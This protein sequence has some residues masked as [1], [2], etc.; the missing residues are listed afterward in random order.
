MV[1]RIH[2]RSL[3]VAVALVAGLVSGSCGSDP[4][5]ANGSDELTP[6]RFTVFAVGT[7]ISTLVV[8][9]TADDINRRLVYNLQVVD[10]VA[11]GSVSA[12]RF[13]CSTC[14]DLIFPG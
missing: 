6:L 9:I 12:V 3:S 7:P 11:S 5:G 13:R 14:S 10:G 4:T 2:W 1:R 8:E